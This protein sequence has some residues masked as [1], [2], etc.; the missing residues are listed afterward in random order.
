M[1]RPAKAGPDAVKTTPV[2]DFVSRA[3]S[4]A[5]LGVASAAALIFEAQAGSS[6]PVEAVPTESV[7][8]PPSKMQMSLQTSHCPSAAILTGAPMGMDFGAVMRIG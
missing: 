8:S 5:A 3:S 6:A 2:A 1:S 7:S 4:F